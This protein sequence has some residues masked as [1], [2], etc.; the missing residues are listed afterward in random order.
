M[1]KMHKTEPRRVL[2]L[3]AETLRLLTGGSNGP[4][5]PSS[6]RL[7]N[8]ACCTDLCGGGGGGGGSIA[9]CFPNCETIVSQ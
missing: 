5:P 7:S 1:K 3:G 2:V 9:T 6:D 4:I 8:M